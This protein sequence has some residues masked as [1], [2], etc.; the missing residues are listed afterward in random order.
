M[1]EK[2]KL[3]EKL[4]FAIEE[5]LVIDNYSS[6]PFRRIIPTLI[7]DQFKNRSILRSIKKQLKKYNLSKLKKKQILKIC[8]TKL[9]LTRRIGLLRSMQKLFKYW[10]IAHLPF[11]IVMLVIMLVHVAVTVLFGYTWIFNCKW[12]ENEQITGHI[13]DCKGFCW[14]V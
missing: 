13:L 10:H 8:K 12:A 4:L 9:V 3:D 2:Y 11:A 6:I 5:Y 14:E 1:R 7:K